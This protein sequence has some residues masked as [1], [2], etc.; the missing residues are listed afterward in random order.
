MDHALCAAIDDRF[1]GARTEV[2]GVRVHAEIHK[3][4]LEDGDIDYEK[5]VRD[6]LV[7]NDPAYAGGLLEAIAQQL[8]EQAAT[9]TNRMLHY[10]A[11]TAPGIATASR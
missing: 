7:E 11:E 10:C 9:L 5:R 4:R 8:E 1:A 6:P 2:V 3:V